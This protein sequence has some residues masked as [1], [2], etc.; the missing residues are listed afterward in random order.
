MQACGKG[1]LTLAAAA[2]SAMSALAASGPA[3]RAAAPSAKREASPSATRRLETAG[4]EEGARAEGATS[5]ASMS[6]VQITKVKLRRSRGKAGTLHA[7]SLSRFLVPLRFA[8]QQQSAG[9]ARVRAMSGLT[10]H[11]KWAL[12]GWAVSL[13]VSSVWIRSVG[14]PVW[15]DVASSVA[16][17]LLA[18]SALWLDPR[19]LPPLG[20]ALMGVCVGLM[21]VD[22]AFDLVI[23]REG[24]VRLGPTTVTPGRCAWPW[25]HSGRHRSRVQRS[26]HDSAHGGLDL[27]SREL[28]AA[29]FAYRCLHVRVHAC[30]VRGR[31]ERGM[32]SG[33]RFSAA[34][35]RLTHFS[36]PS[37]YPQPTFSLPYAYP[38][39]TLCLPYAYPAGA[40][41]WRTTTT[42]RC[43]TR[44]MSTWPCAP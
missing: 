2:M 44:R 37:A 34:L 40:G 10:A 27:A 18:L 42:T 35:S 8:L 31:R 7:L 3:A 11:Q 32:L 16:S 43:S 1:F 19:L 12:T 26:E 25:V 30:I 9:E 23:I 24:S 28:A 36:L 33:R 5:S 17:H 4:R 22:M 29:A 6:K 13:V 39:P 41:W 20:C 38:M 21:L 14:C 15:P